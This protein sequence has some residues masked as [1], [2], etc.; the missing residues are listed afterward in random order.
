MLA[1]DIAADVESLKSIMALFDDRHRPLRGVAHLAGAED[2]GVI[3]TMTLQ[4]CATAFAA[5]VLCLASSPADMGPGPGPGHLRHVFVYLC[6][7]M[8]MLGHTSYAAANSFLDAL[9]YL[10]RAQ[11]LPP[12]SIAYGA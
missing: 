2:N 7:V 6:G 4:C 10:R 11:R 9:A 5:N 1:C 12:T 8:G 3:S